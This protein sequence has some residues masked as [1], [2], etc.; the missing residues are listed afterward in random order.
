V[1][2]LGLIFG[3]V[4]G[5]L[6]GVVAVGL[7]VALGGAMR[8]R[9]RI[10]KDGLEEAYELFSSVERHPAGKGRPPEEQYPF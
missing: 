2:V 7:A 8:R 3:L 6:W 1:F 4:L 10:Q 5:S 9:P